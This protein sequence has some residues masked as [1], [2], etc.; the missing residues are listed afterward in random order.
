[1]LI[2]H[3]TTNVCKKKNYM[4]RKYMDFKFSNT[5]RVKGFK[6]EINGTKF[7]GENVWK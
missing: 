1:M 4:H 7:L 3:D 6:K 2:K 5:K